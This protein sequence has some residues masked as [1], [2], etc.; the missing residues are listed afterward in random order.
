MAGLMDLN[1]DLLGQAGETLRAFCPGPWMKGTARAS[2]CTMLL[3]FGGQKVICQKGNG[4]QPLKDLS[5][6]CS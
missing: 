4:C 6:L 1:C 2:S 3:N 5:L